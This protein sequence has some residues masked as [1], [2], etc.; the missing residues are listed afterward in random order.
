MKGMKA[1]D[2]SVGMESNCGVSL[3]PPVSG[4]PTGALAPDLGIDSRPF[5]N[6]CAKLNED[7]ESQCPAPQVDVGSRSSFNT[8]VFSGR[9]G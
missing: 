4:S 7:E 1:N 6:R 5:I 8:R 9:S 3:D 2:M